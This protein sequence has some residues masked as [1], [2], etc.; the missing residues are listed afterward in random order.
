MCTLSAPTI[1]DLLYSI[2]CI[3]LSLSNFASLSVCASLCVEMHGRFY[4]AENSFA[5]NLLGDCG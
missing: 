5:H 2:V 3:K 4:L 1:A